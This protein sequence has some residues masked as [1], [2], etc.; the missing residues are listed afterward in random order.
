MSRQ[1]ERADARTGADDRRRSPFDWRDT[2]SNAADLAL[3]G[4]VTFL[5]ALPVVTAGSALGAAS[6]AVHEWL[7]IQRMPPMA[8]SGRRYLR[9]IL[10]G[11]AAFVA[12]ALVAYLLI[13]NVVAIRRG[14]VPGGTPLVI[15]ALGVAVLAGGLALLILVEVG[16]QGGTGW[17]TAAVTAWRTA[18]DRPVAALANGG[19]LALAVFLSTILP[20]C[21]PILLGYV[22]FAAHVIS[23]GG[24]ALIP[25][26]GGEDQ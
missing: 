3:L 8:T 25:P 17:R 2:L 21:I 13:W 23:P 10:P 19:V 1:R 4:I 24:S 7:P 22:I 11:L 15:A 16:R 26:A 9:G 14:T 18:L 12:F 5:G 6:A 20:V